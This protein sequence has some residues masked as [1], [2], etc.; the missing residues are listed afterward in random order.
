MHPELMTQIPQRAPPALPSCF[1][2]QPDP[3]AAQRAF[4][5]TFLRGF[6]SPTLPA[7]SL[8]KAGGFATG[9]CT[10]SIDIVPEHFADFFRIPPGDAQRS[11]EHGVAEER[12]GHVSVCEGLIPAVTGS[13]WQNAFGWGLFL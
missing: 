8:G 7:A 1:C 5:T 3:G 13:C 11:W 2:C 9:V 10:V 6:H 12:A 4:Y